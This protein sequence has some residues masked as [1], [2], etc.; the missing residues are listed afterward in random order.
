MEIIADIE[1][2]IILS[3]ERLGSIMNDGF[4]ADVPTK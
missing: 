4:S 2:G 1:R 3:L